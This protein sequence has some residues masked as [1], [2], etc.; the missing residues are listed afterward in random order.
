MDLN[1]IT[2]AQ[3]QLQFFRDFP[4]RPDYISTNTYNAGNTT[5]YNGLFWQ[6]IQNGLL[7]ILPGS[8]SSRW[9]L[10]AG[11]AL[12]YVQPQDITNAF[13][14]AQVVF[15]L[16]LW[17]SDAIT[18]LAYLYC[19]AHYLV[20]DLRTAAQGVDST[21]NFP[22]QSRSVGRRIGNL[23]DTGSLQGQ[24][25][26][27]V[28][29]DHRV[30]TEISQHVAAESRRQY[31]LGLWGNES[32]KKYIIFGFMAAF[33]GW[34]C[35]EYL[36][37]KVI[38]PIISSFTLGYVQALYFEWKKKMTAQIDIKASLNLKGFEALRKGLSAGQYVK[39]GVFGDHKAQRTEQKTQWQKETTGDHSDAT[40][41]P[42]LA[43]IHEFGSLSAHI[44]ERSFL[45]MPV[46]E[47]RADILKFGASKKM[48]DL[49]KAGEKKKA[50]GLLG[51][52]A[53]NVINPHS[54]PAVSASGHRLNIALVK[55]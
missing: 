46:Q 19:T 16:D 4:Y 27:C 30:R 37:W 28:F 54:I 9:Q 1:T 36:G 47:K 5:Y 50:L 14:E 33:N 8:D 18:T 43:I 40:T 49:L 20:N 32:M 10:M 17:P 3:F 25:A 52:F 2:T 15:N 55:S 23:P 13:A 48:A 41:N 45:R 38:F 26:A 39:V 12:D 44:P 29:H 24:P 21:G 53:E 11:N 7:N 31:R 34:L 35:A 51:A 22:V 6:A 42:E